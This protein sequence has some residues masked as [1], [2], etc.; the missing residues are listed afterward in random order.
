S[1]AMSTFR[2]SPRAI[3]S[4]TALSDWASASARPSGRCVWTSVSAMRAGAP[5]SVSAMCF[6]FVDQ[7]RMTND[8]RKYPFVRLSSLVVGHFV[9]QYPRF[10]REIVLYA[11]NDL[12]DDVLKALNN[13]KVLN[14]K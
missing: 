5:T 3:S 1:S 9:L 2:A 4:Y 12:T 10:Y 6:R 7:R 8:Q 13:I 11:E 14:K